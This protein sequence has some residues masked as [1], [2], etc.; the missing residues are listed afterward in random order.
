MSAYAK[1]KNWEEELG[2]NVPT[3][4]QEQDFQ[5][6]HEGNYSRSQAEEFCKNDLN[7]LAAIASPTVFQYMFPLIYH[8]MWTLLLKQLV[9][10]TKNPQVAIGVPRGFAKTTLV[11]LFVLYCMLFT[12]IKFILIVGNTE[13]HA[14]NII[15]D[16]FDML[17][18]KNIINIF[19]DYRLGMEKDTT[20]L[21]KF[22]F[23]GRVI[24]IAGMGQGGSIRGL[25]V[26]NERPDLMIFDD[27][28]SKE[29]SESF[30][31]SQAIERWLY[32]TAMKAKSPRG[33]MFIFLANMYP[34]PNSLL[35]KMKSNATWIKFIN[36]AI[37]ADGTSMW[38]ELRSLESLI[39]EFDTD[40]AA[41]HPEIFLSEVMNDTEAGV[42]TSVD[43]SKL[44]RW[45]WVHGEKPQGK[46]IIID[47][48]GNKVLYNGKNKSDPTAIGYFEVYDG[49]PVLREVIEETLSPGNTIRKAILLSLKYNIRCIAVESTS[50]QSTLLYW[51]GEIS[52][53]IGL[54]GFY[55]VELFS[56]NNSKN[57]RI[58][59]AL[60]QLESGETVIHPSLVSLVSNKIANFNPLK[61][62]NDDGILDLFTYCHKTIELYEAYIS[63]EFDLEKEIAMGQGVSEDVHM[64]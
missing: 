26:K 47:P 59:I 10:I 7:G 50:Y 49:V 45:K 57:N 64:F 63:S 24:I 35:K 28:Q 55:F 34:G 38:E 3:P 62:D 13:R 4:K 52:K 56:G 42:N 30:A 22:G 18:E 37:L 43:F 23:R 36:G 19:G 39:H 17:R 2:L 51:F 53:Q 6:Q 61:R 27:I 21:K 44:H 58:A 29:E 9:N 1:P 32:G 5:F 41:G 60:K 8:A 54:E 14:E 25:N 12:N 16:I 20:T 48:S 40:I 15:A 11:K 33:C 46:F 31:V